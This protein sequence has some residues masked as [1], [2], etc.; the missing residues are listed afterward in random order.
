MKRELTKT[1]K[2]ILRLVGY[3]REQIAEK[4][5]LSLGTVKTHLTNIRHKLNV[6]STNQ[7]LIVALQNELMDAK[8]IDCGFWDSR[9]VY[10]EDIQTVDMRKI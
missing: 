2:K 8:E 7:A 10:I 1:E 6:K 3:T 5:C 9:N 4:L